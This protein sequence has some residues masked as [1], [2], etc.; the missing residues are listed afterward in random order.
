MSRSHAL[1][2]FMSHRSGTMALAYSTRMTHRFGV[3]ALLLIASACGTDP[4]E[5]SKDTFA[6]VIQTELAARPACILVGEPLPW[7]VPVTQR[8]DAG[9]WRDEEEPVYMAGPRNALVEAGLIRAAG[10]S[11][12]LGDQYGRYL[13]RR[14][15]L[16]PAGREA[17]RAQVSTP[18]SGT[19]PGFCGGERRLVEVTRYTEP[20]DFVGTRST[21]VHY[22]YRIENP[23]PWLRHASIRRHFATGLGSDLAALE[24]PQEA[25]MPLVLMSDGWAPAQRVTAPR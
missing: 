23:A 24:A 11:V 12:Y 16:T 17:Y 10:D 7:S 3:P 21:Q 20:A 8:P 2:V 14:Y 4:R 13:R 22:T 5:P 9:V 19:R 1:P 6:T 18:M 25:R 15:E